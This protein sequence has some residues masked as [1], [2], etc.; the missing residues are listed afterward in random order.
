[1]MTMA[2]KN[3]IFAEQKRRYYAGNR[4]EKAE[5]LNHVC[6]VTGIKRK[7]AIRKFKVLQKRDIALRQEKRG[8]E[9]RYGPD[10]TAALKDVWEAG[11]RVCGELLH[12]M[13]AEYVAIM[14]RDGQWEKHDEAVTEKLLAMS[15]GT[16][17]RRI[18]A[19]IRILRGNRGLSGTK[20]SNLKQMIPVFTGPWTDKPPGYGQIDTV[21]H[22]GS[23]LLGDLVHTVQYTDAATMLVTP[24][25]QWNKS[26]EATQKSMAGIK[27]RLPFS[28]LGAHPDSGSEYLNRFVVEWC[29]K[30]KIELSRSRPNHKNDNMYVEE[31]NGHVI[32][33][34]VGYIRLDCVE[35]VDALNAFYDVMTPYLM[36]FVAIRRTEKKEK[37]GSKYLRY[38][39]KKAKTPYQRI[40]DHPA[41]DEGLKTKLRA[42][43]EKLNPLIL[44]REME[45]R[46]K[47]V[48]AIQKR[49][50]KSKV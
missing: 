1:M 50:G 21:V 38:Y 30:E 43:H 25:A 29:E 23:S 22:C 42:E 35:A 28:W 47:A 16:M 6:A 11:N 33:R 20:P 2:T 18:G 24:R 45:M 7:G 8:R 48:Y 31:R 27:E 13:I 26:Q 41:M 5:I 19:F 36:H 4:Q 49:Y 15:E 40:L 9:T 17:K 10:I 3:E 46:L 37:V 34:H 39:E 44:Q 14:R 32:R 12:P